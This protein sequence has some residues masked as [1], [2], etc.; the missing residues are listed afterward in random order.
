M[1]ELIAELYIIVIV[2]SPP[3]VGGPGLRWIY[4]DCPYSL[5]AAKGTY[6]VEGFNELLVFWLGAASWVF[7][8][9]CR[10]VCNIA[11]LVIVVRFG[12]F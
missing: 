6:S 11:G 8:W 7:A 2:L 5:V 12:F 10:L 9:L 3:E 1:E 4:P